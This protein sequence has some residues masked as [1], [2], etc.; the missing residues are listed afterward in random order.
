MGDMMQKHADI[1]F[2]GAFGKLRGR[3]PV[4]RVHVYDTAGTRCLKK[5]EEEDEL[6]E[7]AFKAFQ[8]AMGSRHGAK[9]VSVT[10]RSNRRR[11]AH[12][13][14]LHLG[15]A[16]LKHMVQFSLPNT[17][18]NRDECPMKVFFDCCYDLARLPKP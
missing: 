4:L 10:L 17:C 3:V 11:L 1:L 9:N 16:H 12:Q 13:F 18:C 7:S 15:N 8:V 14:V 5:L 2:E 6:C